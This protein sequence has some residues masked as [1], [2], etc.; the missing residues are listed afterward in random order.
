[1]ILMNGSPTPAGSVV[2]TEPSSIGYELMDA[3]GR[4]SGSAPASRPETFQRR[5]GRPDA[6]ENMAAENNKK[7]FRHLACCVADFNLSDSPVLLLPLTVCAD[8]RFGW[9]QSLCDRLSAGGT[10]RPQTSRASLEQHSEGERPVMSLCYVS[11][12][13]IFLT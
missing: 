12:L 3:R 11:H 6:T 13:A 4:R 1:M 2:D 8:S 7:S 5:L 9:S 10:H